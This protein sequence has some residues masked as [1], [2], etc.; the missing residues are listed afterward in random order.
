MFDD[1]RSETAFSPNTDFSILCDMLSMCFDGF[2]AN[3]AVYARVGNTLE[4]QLFKKVSSLYR[5]LAERLLSQVGELLR[6]TGTM[7]P[8]PGYIAAAYLSALNA[9][10]KYAIRRVMSVNWQV[11]RRIGKW[12]KKLDD[13]V[14]AKMIIDY[15]AS[16]QMVLDNVQRQRALAKL[17]DK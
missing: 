7:N 8:E 13:N 10:D 11:L 1:P 3:S 6:D 16:I 15:L 17:I 2:F 9:P 12:V 4:K 5:R 14:S